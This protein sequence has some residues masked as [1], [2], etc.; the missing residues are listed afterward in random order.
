M[1]LDVISQQDE[2]K[3][4]LDNL[5]ESIITFHDGKI[6]FRNDGFDNLFTE[7]FKGSFDALVSAGQIAEKGKSLLTKLD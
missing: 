6:D 4:V 2:M 1:L 7:S 3:Q 5:Q